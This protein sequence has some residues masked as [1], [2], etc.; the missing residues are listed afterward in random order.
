VGISRPLRLKFRCPGRHL[1]RLSLALIATGLSSATAIPAGP[2]PEIRIGVD[3]AAPYQSWV[4]GQGPVGFTVDVLNEAA[5]RRGFRLRWVECPEGPGRA[6][7]SGKVDIWPLVSLGSGR[8][9]KVYLAEPWLENQYAT[10]WKRDTFVT[11]HQVPDLTNRVVSVLKLPYTL[12]LASRLYSHSKLSGVPNRTIAL[13]ELCAG[14][15]DAAFMEIRILEPML[16]ERPA[17]CEAVKLG[18]RVNSTLQNSMT[19]ASTPSFQR[20]AD[21]LRAAIGAMFLDGQFGKIVDHWFVF[22]NIEAHALADYWQQRERNHYILAAL[23][24]MTVLAVLLVWAAKRARHARGIAEKA[25]L[26]KTAFLANVSHEIRTPMNGVLGM[27]DLLLTTPL[28]PDQQSWATIIRESAQIQLALV[29]DLLDSAK[30]EAGML[31]L[32]AIPFSLRKI[33]N[34]VESS[35]SGAAAEKGIS[36]RLHVQDLLPEALI[37]DPLRVRQI[38]CNLV[39]NAVK[40]TEAGTVAISA[41]YHG[42]SRA[43]R[44]LLEVEDTGIGIPAECQETIFDSFTQADCGTTRR[45]GGTGLGLSICRSLIELMGGTIDLTSIPDAGSTFRVWL[46]LCA[47]DP[48]PQQAA[49]PSQD[50]SLARSLPILVV[51]DNVIN[52]KV[53]SAMLKSLG[54]TVDLAKDG[55]EALEKFRGHSYAAVLMDFQMPGI[56]GFET[57]RAIRALPREGRCVP[58][59]PVI[60]LSAGTTDSDRQSA[61]DSGMIDCLS[62][63]V[64][65]A[66]LAAALQRWTSWNA[67]A[68]TFPLPLVHSSTD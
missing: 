4:K 47:A 66:E 22:S 49:F 43:S 67:P 48:T 65:R 23:T 13:E 27:A 58:C 41:S 21:E 33:L 40:F 46:P 68:M 30:I 19:L 1:G 36:L 44:V 2:T 52:Q 8:Q 56:S 34:D 9:M 32:E 63:P 51:E 20:E 14:K 7:K 11:K 54:L 60:G 5:R 35:F 50:F 16:L 25:N 59:T 12:Q 28:R 38:V 37:G 53:A 45:Y 55:F 26:A 39:N 17:G 6:L 24:G 10:V 57:T 61:L 15:S 42:A 29:N 31:R 18:V 64:R 62:K 3:Q